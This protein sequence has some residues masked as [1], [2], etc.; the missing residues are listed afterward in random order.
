[1][2][3]SRFPVERIVRALKEVESGTAAREVCRRLGVTEQTF[4]RWRAQYGGLDLT[5]AKRMRELLEE[6]QRLKRAVAELTLDNQILQ[7]VNSKKW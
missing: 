5:D 1:M 6:N 2:K 7:D 4:Y 3:K